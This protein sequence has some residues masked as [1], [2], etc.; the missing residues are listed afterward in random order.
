MD[1]V[2]RGES[3]VVGVDGGLTRGRDED[4]ELCLGNRVMGGETWEEAQEKKIFG[5]LRPSLE[6]YREAREIRSKAM[7][8]R[9]SEE[10]RAREFKLIGTGGFRDWN[11]G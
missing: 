11:V 3:C 8:E 9:K 7:A 2:G 5:R 1:F 10:T 4:D 6:L